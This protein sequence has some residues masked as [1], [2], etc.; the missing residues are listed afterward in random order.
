[1][2][3]FNLKKN[4]FLSYFSTGAR[5]S[6][7]VGE[8]VMVDCDTR[9]SLPAPRVQWLVSG[10]EASDVRGVTVTTEHREEV[11]TGRV[12]TSSRIGLFVTDEFCEVNISDALESNILEYLHCNPLL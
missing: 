7:E 6:Y 4:T 3:L 9:A 1:M 11:D 10:H 12:D 2:L 5:P 8:T